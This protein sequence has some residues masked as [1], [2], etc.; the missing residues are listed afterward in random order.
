VK[1]LLDAL[2]T[3]W[4][5]P[6]ALEP[7]YADDAIVLENMRDSLKGWGQGRS[8]AAH[9]TGTLYARPFA[10]VPAI[11]SSDGNRMRVSGYVR[12]GE[13][14]AARNFGYFYLELVSGAD[15]RP[16]IAVDNRIFQPKPD[17]QDTISGAQLI[18]M[19]DSAH[20]RQAVL[21]SDAYWFD[22]PE[23]R[24]PGQSWRDLYPLVRAEN[25]WTGEEAAR[26][27]RRLVAF[28]SF[29]PLADYAT[30]ELE[31][32]KSSG[33]F[34]GLK[35]HIQQS[36][37]D[38]A[39]P[40]DL[41]RLRQ[42]FATA[43]RLGMPITVHAQTATHYDAAAARTLVSQVFTAAPHVPVIVAHLWGGGPFAAEPLHVYA[44]SV[45][46]GAPGTRNL[47]FDVAEAALVA[48]GRKEVL[49]EIAA[50]IRKI[51]PRRIL[52]GSDAVGSSTLPP[53]KAAAQFRKDVPLTE[54]EFAIIARNLMPFTRARPAVPR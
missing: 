32:C 14:A 1:A 2:A 44:D 20:I 47:Y 25:D 26:S 8:E 49:D 4:N 18:A 51:G 6:A 16:R 33:R 23:Y 24:A 28:C 12:R 48:A 41:A 27:G 34:A 15:G 53:I 43:D 9:Y 30:A 7:L 5:E 54:E 35:L 36:R 11:F 50:A 19:L 17:Y 22:S 37:V 52:F 3:H 10:I 46:A 38:L 39:N 29:N 31:R 45:A 13:G 21:L 42:V 40:A